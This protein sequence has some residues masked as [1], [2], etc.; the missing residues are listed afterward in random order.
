[1][2]IFNRI[3]WRFFNDFFVGSRLNRYECFLVDAKEKGFE[4]LTMSELMDSIVENSP[5]PEKFIFLRH[6]LDSDTATM[7]KMVK[8]ESANG[9]RSTT[10]LRLST[11]DSKTINLIQS[12]GSEIGYHFEELSKFCLKYGI[13]SCETS[14]KFLPD[15]RKIFLRNLDYIESIFNVSIR[16]FAAHGDFINRKIGLSNT[17]VLQNDEFRKINDIFLEAYDRKLVDM[18][19]IYITDKC[20]PVEFSPVSIEEAVNYY[21]KIY[22]VSHPRQWNT[23]LFCNLN[24]YFSRFFNF[25]RWR[26]NKIFFERKLSRGLKL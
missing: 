25:Y 23:S 13:D 24:E 15:I 5:L 1:L 4:F 11:F 6:D 16:S 7:R 18:F 2:N 21:D 20:L 14:K 8:I 22:F 26:V 19:D 12:A 17:E 9:I 3:Y 10:F